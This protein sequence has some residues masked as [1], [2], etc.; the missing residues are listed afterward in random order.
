MN[1]TGIFT[2]K[3]FEAIAQIAVNSPK[4]IILFRQFNNELWNW[5]AVVIEGA[6]VQSGDNLLL[7]KFDV[8]LYDIR[9]AS[10]IWDITF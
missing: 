6:S 5:Y 9:N 8:S 10:G 7:F 1:F 3:G 4:E 2:F